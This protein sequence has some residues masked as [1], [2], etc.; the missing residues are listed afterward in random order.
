ML[1]IVYEFDT[2]LGRIFFVGFP[3]VLDRKIFDDIDLDLWQFD[4]ASN[5]TEAAA[6]E[7]EMCLHHYFK[8]ILIW[9]KEQNSYCVRETVNMR[10]AISI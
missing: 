10:N 7:L 8:Y 9:A 3:L 6:N 4:T 1:L 5:N 2:N